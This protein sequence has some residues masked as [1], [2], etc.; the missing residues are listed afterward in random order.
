VGKVISIASE[1]SRLNEVIK[2]KK[3]LKKILLVGIV[4]APFA[5]SAQAADMDPPAP[6][7]V[8]DVEAMTGFYLRADAGWSFLE[9]S[10]G[11]DDNRPLIGGGVGYRWN[12]M[13]RTD[14][15]V[16]WA[17]KYKVAPGVDRSATTVLGNAYLDLSNDTA[18]TPYVGLGAGYSFVKDGKDGVAVAGTA[19]VAVDLTQNMALDVSYRYRQTMVSGSD[20]K[21]H[22][23]MTGLRFSF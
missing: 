15:T 5:V 20:P 4:A 22:Q 17:G 7:D 3:F 6:S 12:D 14:L 21:E 16:D 10:G 1:Y 11:A 18:F 19:G 9:W 2:M 13:V 8:S 23:I